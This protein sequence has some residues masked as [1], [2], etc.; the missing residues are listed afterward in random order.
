MILRKIDR[1]LIVSTVISR[2]K[3]HWT[4]RRMRELHQV[5][6]SWLGRKRVQRSSDVFGIGEFCL[7][8]RAPR[9]FSTLSS[10]RVRQEASI[11]YVR[12]DAASKTPNSL[13]SSSSSQSPRHLFGV[14]IEF[15][16]LNASSR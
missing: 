3:M 13:S 9:S 10:S 11:Y 16:P 5:G 6:Q 12:E 14:Q 8:V 15:L 1:G 2:F 7:H 4:A